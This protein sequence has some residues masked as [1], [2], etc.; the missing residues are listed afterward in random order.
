MKIK[1]T[2]L[3]ILATLSGLSSNALAATGAREDSSMLLVWAFLGMCALI[4]IIQLMP[5]VFMTVGMIKGLLQS[6]KPGSVKAE[7]SHKD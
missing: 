2:V 3:S 6:S 7:A 5:A 4:V 1:V